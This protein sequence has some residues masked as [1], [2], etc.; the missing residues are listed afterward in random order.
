MT[1][2]ISAHQPSYLPWLGYFHKVLLSDIFVFYDHVQYS[3]KDYTTRNYIKSSKGK[4]LLTVPVKKSK[5]VIIND[6][7]IYNTIPWRRNHLKSIYYNYK[8]AEY[9]ENYYYLFE[10]FYKN[11]YEN[12]SDMNM[13][14]LNMLLNIM[15]IK[16]IIKRSSEM[17][18][19]SS[20]S[21][22]IIQMMQILQSNKIVFGEHGL[23]YVDQ[24][25]FKDN[26]IKCYFQKYNHPVYKQLFGKYIPYLS[27]IDL[28][29]NCGPST[30]SII[31]SNNYDKIDLERYYSKISM[32]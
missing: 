15:N 21:S 11:E 9:F 3:N 25:K 31:M 5:N 13:C 4:N 2:I 14:M 27:V 16:V 18:I 26:D 29:F 10:E 23:E 8:K 30:K 19:V 6:L 1:K 7:K 17:N 32:C 28:M 20:S 24:L 12:L 22:G